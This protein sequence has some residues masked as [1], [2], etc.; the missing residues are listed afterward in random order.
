MTQTI[1][2]QY[3]DA[4]LIERLTPLA[5][6]NGSLRGAKTALKKKGILISEQ[7]LLRIKDENSGLYVALANDYA[8]ALEERLAQEYRESALAATRL[9]RGLVDGMQE[10][11]EEEGL[12]EAPEKA[13]TAAVKLMQTSTDKLLT[14]TGRPVGGQSIDPHEAARELV[15]LGVY[16]IAD[17]ETTAEE[18][19]AGETESA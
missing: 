2:R 14:I 3:S 7:E 8:S 13:L 16:K 19:P 11:L 18:I 1:Q 17:A 9:A 5:S 10:R 6:A 4:E 12:P 15:R